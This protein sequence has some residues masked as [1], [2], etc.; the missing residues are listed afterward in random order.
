M[1]L[2]YHA[3]RLRLVVFL[4]FFRRHILAGRVKTPA[5]IP[6]HPFECCKHDILSAA[7]RPFPFDELFLV[8]TV[9]RFR[10]RAMPLN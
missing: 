3:F 6:G 5:V 2:T 1:G 8:K 10:R 4:V 7:P 9:Q